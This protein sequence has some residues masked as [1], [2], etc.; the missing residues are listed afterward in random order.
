MSMQSRKVQE[1]LARLKK[2]GVLTPDQQNPLQLWLLVVMHPMDNNPGEF[3]VTHGK[4]FEKFSKRKGFE[5]IGHG[6]DRM[7]L[8]SAARNLT[9]ALGENYQPQFSAA[10]KA[11]PPPVLVE[12]PESGAPTDGSAQPVDISEELDLTPKTE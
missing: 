4:N 9:K 2:M 8:T 1:Q 12:D 5:V 6:F 3:F 7:A 10:R 11:T